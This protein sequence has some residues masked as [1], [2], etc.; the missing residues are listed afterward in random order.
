LEIEKEDKKTP[1]MVFKPYLVFYRGGLL[2]LGGEGRGYAHP[3]AVYTIFLLDHV[4]NVDADS[5]KEVIQILASICT[6]FFFIF[7]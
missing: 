2:D 5:L 4:A 1:N 7:C 3:I 6:Q